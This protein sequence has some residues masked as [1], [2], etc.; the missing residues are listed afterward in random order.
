MAVLT[1]WLN[2]MVKAAIV[3][4]SLL[5]A[6]AV[7]AQMVATLT[8]QQAF[9]LAVQNYPLIRQ[10]GLLQQS[11]RLSIE[12]ISSNLLPQL[13]VNGQATYQ[14]DVT[15]VNIPLPGIKVPTPPKD[16]YRLT[17]EADQLLYD[18]G[19]TKAQQNI[20][21]LHTSVEENRLAVERYHLKER[22]NQLYFSILYQDE[23]LK[24]TDLT[25]K[26]IQ[27]GIDKVKPQVENGVAL[28]S[29]LQILQAQLLQTAQRTIEIKATRKGLTDALSV[30]LPQPISAN[31]QLEMPA[32]LPV[33][34]YGYY[35]PGTGMVPKPVVA[36]GRTTTVDTCR[37][38][39]QSNRFFSGWI[40]QAGIKLIIQRLQAFLYH[41]VKAKLVVGQFVQQQAG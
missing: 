26:D 17:A 7:P 11:S 37:H 36:T 3:L 31:T 21:S 20:Q 6:A 38:A 9:S 18:G 8:L 5:Y 10:Q 22:I 12:N 1:S 39:A 4:A 41:R 19:L 28:R 27:A 40:W 23:L 32:D 2:S 34:R 24:Q 30:F 35:T 25:I 29:N 15:S 33:R 13:V 14:S 16:Q